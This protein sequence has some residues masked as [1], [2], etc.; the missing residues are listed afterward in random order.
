ME[1]TH[2]FDNPKS[3]QRAALEQIRADH[4]GWE[5]GID[6]NTDVITLRQ[7]EMTPA[8]RRAHLEG[9]SPEDSRQRVLAVTRTMG[10]GAGVLME[11]SEAG[12]AR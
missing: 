4:P 11:I 9:W 12:A 8:Q 2:N 10:Q 5:V 1:L 7:P 6:P 3:L